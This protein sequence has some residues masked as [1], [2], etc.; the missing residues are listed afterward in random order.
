MVS[1]YFYDSLIFFLVDELHR[2]E[3]AEHI[4]AVSESCVILIRHIIHLL[5]FAWEI[6]PRSARSVR[7]VPR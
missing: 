2:E 1:L 7:A 4:H 6:R 5:W 3:Q